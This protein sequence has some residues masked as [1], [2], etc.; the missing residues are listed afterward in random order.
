MRVS[1][2]EFFNRPAQAL[3]GQQSALSWMSEE[4]ASGKL[5]NTIG[6]NA[7]GAAQVISINQQLS[8]LSVD[9]QSATTATNNLQQTTSALSSVSDLI[10]KVRQIA[11]Q[12]ANGTVNAS[13]RRTLANS[14]SSALHEMVQLANPQTPGGTYLFSGCQSS[15]QPF[16]ISQAG[17]VSFYGDAGVNQVNISKHISV[18]ISASGQ[19]I[20]M[21]TKNGNGFAVATAASGNAGGATVSVGGVLNHAAATTMD[22]SH[23]SYQVSFTSGAR[24]ALQYEVVDQ[25][26]S[27]VVASGAYHSDMNLQIGGSQV[28]FK[29][30]PVLG[31]SFTLAPAQRQSIFQTISNL[32]STLSNAGAGG[33][34]NAQFSQQMGDVISALDQA[35]NT[36]LG[37]QSLI[38]S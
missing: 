34:S 32:Q 15:T 24:G 14:A 9:G 22:L 38:G 13:E 25:A 29:G 2:T 12:A 31:D 35:S 17:N 10:L 33:Q 3:L 36:V 27:S 18:P 23:T 30:F 8:Q 16:A 6:D 26:T 1:T 7:A 19:P 5:I 4:L 28:S 21:D 11:L 20:F 37:T